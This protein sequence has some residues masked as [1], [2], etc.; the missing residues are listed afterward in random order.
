MDS[1]A[2]RPRLYEVQGTLWLPRPF[3][4][5]LGL[6]GPEGCS[7]TRTG[8]LQTLPEGGFLPLGSRMLV[9]PK[10]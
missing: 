5:L 3:T 1:E 6:E 2:G 10:H 9:S 8:N 7:I 4:A